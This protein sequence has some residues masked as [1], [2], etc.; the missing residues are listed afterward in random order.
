MLPRLRARYCRERRFPPRERR[1]SR[2]SGRAKINHHRRCLPFLVQLIASPALWDFDARWD[3]LCP[4][5]AVLRAFG[6]ACAFAIFCVVGAF[7]KQ[8][9][10]ERVWNER[11]SKPALRVASAAVPF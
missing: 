11:F 2:D 3:W 8:S 10:F 6:S 9:G 5:V 7:I 1:F 4:A